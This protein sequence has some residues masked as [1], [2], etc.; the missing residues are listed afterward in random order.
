MQIFALILLGVLL[1]A[2]AQLMLKAGMSRIGHFEFSAANVIPIGVKV[3]GNL[4]IISGLCMYV[5]SVVVWLLVL[6][7]V[8]VSFAYP[9]LSI[10]YVVNALAANYFFGEPL[11]SIRILGIFVIIAGVYLVAQSSS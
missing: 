10:G 6:S 8:Q 9:M 7:R 11:T 5:I 4:P 2:G 1:N 3:A